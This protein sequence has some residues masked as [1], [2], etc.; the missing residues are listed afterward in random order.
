MAT[1][2]FFGDEISIDKLT[3]EFSAYTAPNEL[4]PRIAMPAF[5]AAPKGAFL[6]VGTERGF[7][8]AANSP[9]VTDLVLL[10]Q[11]PQIVRFNLINIELL[12]R[13]KNR[14]DYLQLRLTA[15]YYDWKG[16]GIDSVKEGDFRWWKDV[17]NGQPLFEKFNNVTRITNEGYWSYIAFDEV[18]YLYSDKLFN[19]ISKMA[20]EDKI[21]VVLG[22]ISDQNLITRIVTEFK[23]RGVKLSIFDVSNAWWFVNATAYKLAQSLVQLKSV[24]SPNS[25]FMTTHRTVEEFPGGWGYKAYP[26]EKL[27][28]FYKTYLHLLRIKFYYNPLSYKEILKS[29]RCSDW[30]ETILM[31]GVYR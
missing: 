20:K 7:I 28:G 15:S 6:T 8:G 13:A 26:F 17:V 14:E 25:L 16:R 9:N 18:N 29:N 19:R 31:M 21:S 2:D 27:E 30:L 12:K 23:K 3:S 11:S 4:N 1:T 5:L 10:D 22:D 24:A